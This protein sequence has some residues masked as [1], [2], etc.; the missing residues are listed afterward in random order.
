MQVLTTETRRHR[1]VT[2]SVCVLRELKEISILDGIAPVAAQSSFRLCLFRQGRTRTVGLPNPLQRPPGA[3]RA[4][5]PPRAS[6]RNPAM[7][8][9]IKPLLCTLYLPMLV[10]ATR[11]DP[12]S[13]RPALP[14]LP[15]RPAWPRSYSSFTQ[16]GN[17]AGKAGSTPV[18]TGHPTRPPASRSAT[19]WWMTCSGMDWCDR[20][21]K[22][23]TDRAAG[24]GFQNPYKSTSE[25]RQ[26]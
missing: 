21:R 8:L 22:R 7:K 3:R 9:R 15:A 14:A 25:F 20:R 1:C 13:R 18:C 11:A 10:A 26:L 19:R 16:A 6:D 24:S 12:I 4:P 5:G 2:E 23:Q 17:D